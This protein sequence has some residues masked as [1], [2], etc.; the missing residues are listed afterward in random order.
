MVIIFLTKQSFS[1]KLKESLG[2]RKWIAEADSG[3]SKWMN[4]AFL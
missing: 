2:S 3:K 4:K 1:R